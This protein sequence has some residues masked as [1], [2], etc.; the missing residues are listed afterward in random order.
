MWYNLNFG[1]LLAE[2]I[3]GN[4]EQLCPKEN[5]EVWVQFLMMFFILNPL[6]ITQICIM[7][8]N[9]HGSELLKM[10]LL[11][12]TMLWAVMD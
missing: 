1:S 3:Y 7:F 11:K 6:L 5:I 4:K 12:K 9:H 2:Q 10:L 8:K